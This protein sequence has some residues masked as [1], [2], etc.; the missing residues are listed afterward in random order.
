[1]QDIKKIIVV[2]IVTISLSSST[3]VITNC[4]YGLNW[5]SLQILNLSPAKERSITAIFPCIHIESPQSS[6]I[7]YLEN[8]SHDYSQ[9]SLKANT[10]SKAM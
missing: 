9:Q 1:M 7:F 6:V 3:Y 2:A 10:N 5:K 8:Q 4:A